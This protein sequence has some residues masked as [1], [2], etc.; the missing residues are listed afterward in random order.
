MTY[1]HKR[2]VIVGDLAIARSSLGGVIF[3]IMVIH[4]LPKVGF[5]WTMRICAFFIL[6]LLIVRNL[7]VSSYLQRDSNPFKLSQ[8]TEPLREINFLLMCIGSFFLCGMRSSVSQ[9]WN[10]ADYGQGECSFR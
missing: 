6:G 8:Y 7:T 3:P 9:C 5:G 2:R 1:F 10:E 4:L